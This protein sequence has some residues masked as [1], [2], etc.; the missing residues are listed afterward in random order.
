MTFSQLSQHYFDE[1]NFI[2]TESKVMK[3]EIY[4]VATMTYI[5]KSL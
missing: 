1:Y 5:F 2:M 3:K 4:A